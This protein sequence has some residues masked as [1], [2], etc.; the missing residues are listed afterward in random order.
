MTK[1]EKLKEVNAQLSG[2]LKKLEAYMFI[3]NVEDIRE[4][5]KVEEKP[6]VLFELKQQV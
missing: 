2:V 3:E 6:K 5:K 4:K 1:L